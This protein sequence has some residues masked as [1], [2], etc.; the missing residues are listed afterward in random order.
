MKLAVTIDVE[1]EGLFRAE[2][3]SGD[4]PTSNVPRLQLLDS[5]FREFDIRPT[6]LVSYQVA[7]S[8]ANQRILPE[9]VSRW[10]GE[11][12]AHLHPWNTPPLGPPAY[13]EPAPSEL[14]PK[15]LL[16]AKLENLT[17]TLQP[18]GVSPV[19]FRMGRFNMGPKMFSV[20]EESEIKVD[21]SICPMRKYYGGPAHLAAP[22]EPYFPDRDNLCRAGSSEVL[23]VPLTVLPVVPGLGSALEGIERTGLVPRTWVSWFAMHLGSLPVQPYWT[24]LRRLKIAVQLHRALGGRV[25]CVFF[26]SSELLPGASPQTS[27]E[28]DVERFIGRLRDF[29]SWLRR[30]ISVKSLTLSELRDSFDRPQTA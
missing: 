15:E 1:E 30:K 26:H 10:N 4:A 12:G 6:L 22:S 24:G 20:L 2:Y 27:T 23:E 16:V 9:L 17:A 19:S 11:I 5:V 3:H 18:M 29:F 7:R 14:I 25:L 8:A 28:Q 13:P 21:S